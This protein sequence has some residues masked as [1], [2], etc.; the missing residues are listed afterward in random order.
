MNSNFNEDEILT[1]LNDIEI[2]E[3][4]LSGENLS[5]DEKKKLKKNIMNKVKL[6]KLKFK[7]SIIAA[8][9]AGLM[10]LSIP[11]FKPH[12]F[13][14]IY[15]KFTATQQEK[16]DTITVIPGL[17]EVTLANDNGLVLN[18]AL[19][20]G[21][22]TLN[23]LYIDKTKVIASIT[24]DGFISNYQ[25]AKYALIDNSGNTYNLKQTKLATGY[26]QSMTYKIEFHGNIQQSSNYTLS[27]LN[28]KVTF[29]LTSSNLAEIHASK[30]LYTVTSGNT[31]LNVTSVTKNNNIL[32]VDYY[33]TYKNTD[34]TKPSLFLNPGR[35]RSNFTEA[36]P[37]AGN[38][39]NKELTE[40]PNSAYLTV[41]DEY[42]NKDYGHSYTKTFDNESFFDLKKL[43]GDKL[44]LILP[45]VNYELFNDYIDKD[46]SNITLNVPKNGKQAINKTYEYKGYKFNILSIERISDQKVRLICKAINS[47]KD[48]KI[49]HLAICPLNSAF[50]C[51]SFINND[52]KTENQSNLTSLVPINGSLT[53]FRSNTPIGDTLTLNGTNL[54]YSYE[55]PFE[56]NLDLNSIKHIAK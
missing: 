18:T 26:D 48:P 32:R 31:T 52:Y 38:S 55:G 21:S 17:G 10:L 53:S 7:K 35:F 24:S 51:T 5:E 19:K 45:A 20:S 16:A 1:M 34:G 11:L 43:K 22:I 36:Q 25:S 41:C 33:F 50:S 13:N 2:S 15:S 39:I 3:N 49:Q 23:K 6:K 28:D 29:K 46:D 37:S 27:L 42:G 47:S 54:S 44:K 30:P 40:N 12:S 56:I 4:E 9:I 8:C 14:V